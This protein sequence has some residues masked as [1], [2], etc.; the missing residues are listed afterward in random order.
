LF[1]D[2]IATL[3][4]ANV[5][6]GSGPDRINAV[7]VDN[8]I[9]FVTTN[10]LYDCIVLQYSTQGDVAIIRNMGPAILKIWLQDTPGQLYTLS[11]TRFLY[12]PVGQSYQFIASD[13]WNIFMTSPTGA[14][15]GF[16]T[17]NVG[18]NSI[19][20]E[21][22]REGSTFGN[23]I[24]CVPILRR[25]T[26]I[27]HDIGKN[28]PTQAAS[29]SGNFGCNILPLSSTVDRQYALGCNIYPNLTGSSINSV[30]IGNNAG[31][32]ETTA[33]STMM[34]G[35]NSLYSHSNISNGSGQVATSISGGIGEQVFRNS[36]IT[37]RR[38]T[39][40][41][42]QAGLGNTTAQACVFMGYQ[43]GLAKST[44]VGGC[45][46]I[47]HQTEMADS[48]A[49]TTRCSYGYQA[50]MS[51]TNQFE[52]HYGYRAGMN[53]TNGTTNTSFGYQSMMNT[54]IGTQLTSFGANSAMNSNITGARQACIGYNSGSMAAVLPCALGHNTAPLASA[55]IKT[56]IGS[57]SM[58]IATS[59]ANL[60]SLGAGT[61][62]AVTTQAS[63]RAY[64][65]QAA[66]ISTGTVVDAI[67]SGALSNAVGATNTVALGQNA[68]SGVTSGLRNM[69][70][71]VSAGSAIIT[72]N[73]NICIN[74]VGVAGD[75]GTIRVGT[76]VSKCYVAGIYNVTTT[77]N[78]AIP[79]RID[80]A[81]QLGTL[82]SSARYKR[83][84]VSMRDLSHGDV[85]DKSLDQLYY[86]KLIQLRPV[87]Y[88]LRDVDEV[89]SM[90]LNPYELTNDTD[91]CFGFISEEVQKIFPEII[92]KFDCN[93]CSNL[94]E[95]SE[96]TSQSE[97]NTSQSETLCKHPLSTIDDAQLYA[98]IINAI[99]YQD[100]LVKKL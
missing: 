99:L 9:S 72:T 48:A 97:V 22:S 40:M 57:G 63:L 45:M 16:D 10:A 19:P 68:L 79:V 25:T 11:Y 62:T 38:L 41:G 14:L 67:G 76:G 39:G 80:S 49:L 12:L 90:T 44:L 86:D 47:G 59:G 91:V 61:L 36:S 89:N 34:L 7:L 43:S 35:H 26:H 96:T 15:I 65:Y 6:A 55:G 23:D 88:K 84:I 92:R 8:G 37:N 78:N 33:I 29:I 66:R 95:L 70:L 17:V 60:Y 77:N 46:G 13:Q 85:S 82:S 1:V 2:G 31:T 3:A 98:I 28:S 58:P 93:R 87:M 27:G 5:I 94:S 50:G 81:G 54:T 83:D 18:I 42:H 71:G 30:V 64:G 73:D 53:V 51:G 69:G 100:K 74:N 75:V 20:G 32:N 24:A 52:Y 21:C 4:S 56:V